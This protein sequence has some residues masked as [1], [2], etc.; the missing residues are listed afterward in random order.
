MK[1]LYFLSG[2]P[3]SGSTVL[4]S[5]LSQHPEMY[6]SPTS[7]L[8]EL[9]FKIEQ[10]FKELDIQ[11][12]YDKEKIFNN[13]TSAILKNFYAHIDEPYILDKH[14][15][16]PQNLGPVKVFL[17]Q[18]PKVICTIRRISEIIVSYIKLAEKDP[19]N[20]IDEELKRRGQEINNYNRAEEIFNHGMNGDNACP[21]KSILIGI[22]K[23]RENIHFVDYNELMN[24]PQEILNGIYKF[25]D[26][27]PHYHDFDNIINACSEDKDSDGWRLKGLHSIRSKLAKISYPPEEI[28]GEE[29]THYYDSFNIEVNNELV[30]KGPPRIW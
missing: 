17:N 6:V 22:E 1:A 26:I 2:L 21:L 13:I 25:L 11:Y 19:N 30:H 3:R 16:W 4:G 9:L 7:P 5:I 10:N 18:E 14:R 28:L 15:A 23:Y 24:Q 12:T 29:R 20:F 27:E 8:F